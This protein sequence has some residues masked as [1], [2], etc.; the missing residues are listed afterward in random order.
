MN[1]ALAAAGLTMTQAFR[2][3]MCARAQERL[4][5]PVCFDDLAHV[6]D[7][8]GALAARFLREMER[9]DF[10]VMVATPVGI[11]GR[12][13]RWFLM[14]ARWRLLV[15]EFAAQGLA[16]GVCAVCGEREPLPFLFRGRFLCRECLCADDGCANDLNLAMHTGTMSGCKL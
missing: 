1:A 3:A 12:R 13:C 4:R 11:W 10:L 9:R 5:R 6:L 2:L 8:E 15:R 14:G 7:V 16:P